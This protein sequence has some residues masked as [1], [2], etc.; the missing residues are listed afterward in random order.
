MPAV[1]EAEEQL[2]KDSL[3]RFTEEEINQIIKRKMR[4]GVYASGPSQ[5]PT[6]SAPQ[7]KGDSDGI[8]NACLQCPD[9][10]V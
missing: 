4:K 1:L 6:Q 10:A 2:L 8:C 5:E 9:I 7:F 3:N